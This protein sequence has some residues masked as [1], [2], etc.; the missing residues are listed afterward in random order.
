MEKDWKRERKKEANKIEN[1]IMREWK[2]GSGTLKKQM[3][4][5][6]SGIERGRGRRTEEKNR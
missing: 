3:T 4:R 2:R 1:R 5:K 6:R